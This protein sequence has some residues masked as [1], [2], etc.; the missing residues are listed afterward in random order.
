MGG[1]CV[2]DGQTRPELDNFHHSRFIMDGTTW[3]TAEH[4]YHAC[5]YPN[6][7]VSREAIRRANGGMESWKL[8]QA[9][10][11]K[12]FRSDWEQVKVDM[13]YA[14]NL[15][16][17]SQNDVLRRVLLSTRG[18]IQ[19]QGG[20]FW[21]TWNEILL[22]RIREE[23]RELGN[24]DELLLS[25][26]VKL[27]DAWRAAAGSADE[28]EVTIVTT[29]A[30][31]RMLPQ[32]AA[33]GG[34]EAVKLQGLDQALHPWV[35]DGIFRVD[36]LTPEVN[37]QPHYRS[38]AGGHLNLGI[39]HGRS[40]WCLDEV[41]SPSEVTGAAFLP[42]ASGASADLPLGSRSWNCFDGKVHVEG[43]LTLEAR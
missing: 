6:D 21:K 8:G 1:P 15:A 19:A 4:Y 34:V 27:M 31:K 30:A 40:A 2:V 25:E 38:S 39:K 14:A 36:K 5:K 43:L 42:V 26:R 11:Q 28:H 33:P 16:K 12:S 7:E 37:G 9:S 17:F 20:L 23:L 22:E 3:P 10:D 18:P 24:R 35:G 13:M 29:W 41:C 32:S